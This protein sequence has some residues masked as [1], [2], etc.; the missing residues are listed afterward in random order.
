MTMGEE[1]GSP[2]LDIYQVTAN[3]CAEYSGSGGGANIL[4]FNGSKF[5]SGMVQL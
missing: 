1:K 2:S 5:P 3:L 4:D